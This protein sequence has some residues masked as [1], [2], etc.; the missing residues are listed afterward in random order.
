MPEAQT[1]LAFDYGLRKI[2][3]AVGNT[4]T[5]RA[6]PLG[7]IRSDERARRFAEIA[8]LLAQWHPDIVVVGLPLTLQGDDQLA[9]VQA[10]RFANQLRGRFGLTV[11]MVDERH[12][13]LEAQAILA[14]HAEDDAMAAAVI[15]Q[16][17]LDDPAAAV[18]QA[19]P[20]AGRS[21]PGWQDTCTR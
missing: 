13:S 5:G 4:V 20:P 18:A 9:T 12:S 17:Y 6:R 7:I 16:R 10:R 14:S 11:V 3:V 1:L 21:C 19:A 2:G 15:L 8:A